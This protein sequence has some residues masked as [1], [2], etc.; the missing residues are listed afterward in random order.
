MRQTGINFRND[1]ISG[2][3]GEQILA[4]GPSGN[5]IEAQS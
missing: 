2:P 4:E 1:F 3:G 5:P